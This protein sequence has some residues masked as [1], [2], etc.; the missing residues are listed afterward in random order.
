MG[1]GVSVGVTSGGEKSVGVEVS[2][3][4]EKSVG[5]EVTSG[6]GDT[7]GGS[8]AVG[9]KVGNR[10]G[11][12]V[13]K[14]KLGRGVTVGLPGLFVGVSRMTMIVTPRMLDGD[15]VEVSIAAIGGVFDAMV[16]PGV[17]VG[18]RIDAM[19]LFAYVL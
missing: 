4:V 13:G 2:G 12:S 8:S 15:E 1:L 19:R 10:V 9:E 5:V 17:G 11:N 14:K 18:L 6:V 7:V 16:A 3:G